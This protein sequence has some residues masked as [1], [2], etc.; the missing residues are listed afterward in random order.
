MKSRRLK[1]S[2]VYALYGLAAI[3]LIGIIYAI[4]STTSTAS[5]DED[6]EKYQYVSKTIFDNVLT[7]NTEENI[8]I[9][10]PY[11]DSE[12]KLLKG[13]YDYKGEAAAQE[14]ALI[15][16]ENTYMQ[17]S[18]VSYGKNDAFQVLAILDGEVTSVEEDDILGNIVQIKHEND[19]I[20]SY[21]S[22]SEVSVKVGSQVKQGDVI[23]KSGK[24][25]LEADLGNH[26]YFELMIKDM[27]VNPE[28]YFDKSINEI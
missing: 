2:A 7:V 4:Q 19:I 18:G 6:K 27:N 1:K 10:K 22:L 3:A 23:G 20:S 14:K 15:Y 24:S 9:A 11:N 16:Y 28:D 8:K 5:F 12:V 17:S 25:N 13:Y 21:Q 26:L